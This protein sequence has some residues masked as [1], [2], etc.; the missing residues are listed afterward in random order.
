MLFSLVAYSE[1]HTNSQPAILIHSKKSHSQLLQKK[2]QRG[3]KGSVPPEKGSTKEEHSNW[4]SSSEARARLGR[5]GA[6]YCPMI[7]L[8][9]EYKAPMDGR[10]R[11]VGTART[12]S[13]FSLT[14]AF[15]S[16]SAPSALITT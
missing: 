16:S 5:C 1:P 10:A 7:L 12:H 8:P 2:D 11:S 4:R 9:Y 13:R 14:L 6:Y 15:A 3:W